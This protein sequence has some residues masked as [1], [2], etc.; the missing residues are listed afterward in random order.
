MKD[1]KIVKKVV[2]V[3]KEEYIEHNEK[4]LLRMRSSLRSLKIETTKN[5]NK[6]IKVIEELQ[7]EIDELKYLGS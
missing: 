1:F 6:K 4:L 7:K 5:I 3:S 2:S